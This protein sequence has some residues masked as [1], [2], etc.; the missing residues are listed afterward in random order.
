MKSN[1]MLQIRCRLDHC[2][3]LAQ[4]TNTTLLWAKL[5]QPKFNEFNSS[6]RASWAKVSVRM[7]HLIT[8]MWLV[9]SST[10]PALFIKLKK[11]WTNGKS[12]ESDGTSR[13]E[14]FPRNIQNWVK[15]AVCVAIARYQKLSGK[16]SSKRKL[17]IKCF[18]GLLNN[19]SFS[20]NQLQAQLN[21]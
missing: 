17:R 18:F 5:Q 1:F 20:L 21:V 13:L 19:K 14:L 16:H 8:A 6:A 4:A 7:I 2:E 9:R 12:H 15:H 3:W 10:S 11:L